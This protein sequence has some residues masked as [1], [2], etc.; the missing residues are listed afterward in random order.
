VAKWFKAKQGIGSSN[1]TF[2][3][4]NAMLV[5]YGQTVDLKVPE[6]ITAIA[7]GIS[8]VATGLS[9][10]GIVKANAEI[11]VLTGH[12][13]YKF[14]TIKDNTKSLKTKVIDPIN[15]I[16]NKDYIQNLSQKI[17]NNL[18]NLKPLTTLKI[19]QGDDLLKNINLRKIEIAKIN[20][21]L[22]RYKSSLDNY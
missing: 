2:Q 20:K 16:P 18:S 3:I 5:S 22:R 21:N 12:L 14:A 11:E 13:E 19:L 9:T 1:V 7:G 17:T 4:S 6:T 15:T 10:M 8:S